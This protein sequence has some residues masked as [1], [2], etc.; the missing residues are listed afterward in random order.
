MAAVET[1]T[2]MADDLEEIAHEWD[3]LP[4]GERVS[5][6]LDWSNEM[7]GLERVAT[8]VTSGLLQPPQERTYRDLL[9]RLARSRSLLDR[10]GLYAPVIPVAER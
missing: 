6:S 7:S 8:E 3:R 4:E 1:A 2:L 10:L 9:A 5:W